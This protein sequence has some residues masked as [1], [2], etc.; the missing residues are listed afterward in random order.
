[1]KFLH[2]QI[3]KIFTYKYILIHRPGVT[4]RVGRVIALFFHDRGTRKGGTLP[5][6][7]DPVPIV[8]EAGWVPGS[9]WTGGIYR[10]HRDSIPGS[11]TR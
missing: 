11:P 3:N 10:R 7:K 9:V 6:V 4:Q 1:M 5:P 2:S 8:Q